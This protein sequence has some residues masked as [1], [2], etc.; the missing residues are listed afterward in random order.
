M[1]SEASGWCP[2]SGVPVGVPTVGY[3]RPREV[4]LSSL[5]SATVPGA[6]S[7]ILAQT[8]PMAGTG[9]HPRPATTYGPAT[10]ISYFESAS[11]GH[12][13]PQFEMY[14]L[15][16]QHLIAAAVPYEVAAPAAAM[17][18]AASQARAETQRYYASLASAGSPTILAAASAAPAPAPALAPATGAAGYASEYELAVAAAAAAP[19]R[20]IP[21]GATGAPYSAFSANS[22]G[23]CQH[24]YSPLPPNAF[25]AWQ[26]AIEQ[27]NFP[28]V[29][30]MRGKCRPGAG[31]GG[32]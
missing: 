25:S 28:Y 23:C 16:S 30:L 27:A 19:T 29:D 24:A 22:C 21:Y 3:A 14:A 26:N 5:A 12:G 9:T 4:Q 1:A 13:L 11:W 31:C 32:L 10:G 6:P 17:A 20:F 8:W 7:T 15:P 18:A 2:C